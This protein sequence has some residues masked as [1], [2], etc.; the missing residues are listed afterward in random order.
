MQADGC[1]PIVAAF[2]EGRDSG[3]TALSVSDAAMVDGMRR[4]GR[5]E[6]ISAAPEGGATLAA[7]DALVA[8]GQIGRD[9][10]V[11]LFNTGGA[12]K[13]LEVLNAKC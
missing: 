8:S 9:E 6:G 11:V 10:L 2:A 1:A 12:L 7:L 4:M 5:L 3:G 13:Y